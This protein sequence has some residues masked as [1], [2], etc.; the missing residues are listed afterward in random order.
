MV[1]F[2]FK[3]T[4][5]FQELK[6]RTSDKHLEDQAIEIT[7]GG[8]N[9]K[10]VNTYIPPLSSCDAGYQTSISKLL[11]LD[12]FINFGDLYAH[13]PLW[14]SKLPDDTRGNDIASEIDLP[15]HVVLNK[16]PALE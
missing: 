2:F 16:K 11:E 8:N 10:L 4:I 13:S 3:D 6:L 1:A 9:I 5:L 12:D 15:N 7:A 14:H